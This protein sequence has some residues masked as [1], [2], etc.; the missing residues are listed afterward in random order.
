MLPSKSTL[1]IIGFST[2]DIISRF[3]TGLR[4]TFWK[5][6]ESLSLRKPS[7]IEFAD[8]LF[9]FERPEIAIIVSEETSLFPETTISFILN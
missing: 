4:T 6:P 3:P 5:S 8:I 9:D 1:L 7:F 2:T